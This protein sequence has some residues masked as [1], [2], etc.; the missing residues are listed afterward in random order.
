MHGSVVRLL[1]QAKMQHDKTTTFREIQQDIKQHIGVTYTNT[2]RDRDRDKV[3][4]KDKDNAQE[5][6]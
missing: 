2:D 1:R 4:H 3:R 6:R 5:E